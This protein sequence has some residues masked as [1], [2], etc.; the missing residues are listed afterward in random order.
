M[1]DTVF[2]TYADPLRLFSRD[3]SMAIIPAYNA[4]ALFGN[5][6]AIVLVNE[7]FL[8]DLERAI[9]GIETVSGGR[10]E[11]VGDV[12]IRHVRPTSHSTLG[13]QRDQ[14]L[15]GSRLFLPSSQFREL[16]AFDCYRTYFDKCEDA[17]AMFA[18]MI[19]KRKSFADFVQV[20]RRSLRV[21]RAQDIPT[22]SDWFANCAGIQVQDGR[23]QQ[24]RSAGAADGASAAHTP[25]HDDLAA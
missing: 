4:T 1:Y 19:Q 2:Q 8:E 12:V 9:A 15:P 17:Q 18:D 21:F 25:V 13:R 23:G 10:P 6:D 20:R 11:G 5:I 16:R 14:C 7:A 3:K 24:C 22:D